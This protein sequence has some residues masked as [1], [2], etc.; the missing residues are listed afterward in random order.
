MVGKFYVICITE[1]VLITLT[2]KVENVNS[3][4]LTEA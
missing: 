1:K 4:I 3:I 2:T